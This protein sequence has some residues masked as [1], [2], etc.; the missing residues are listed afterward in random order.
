MVVVGIGNSEYL[1][2]S[3]NLKVENLVILQTVS[4]HGGE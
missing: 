1:V 3:C 2:D 4:N